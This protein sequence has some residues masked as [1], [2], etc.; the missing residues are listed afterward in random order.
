VL[1]SST[2]TAPTLI[3]AAEGEPVALPGGGSVRVLEQYGSARLE[4]RPSIV[5]KRQRDRSA[6]EFYSMLRV[7]IEGQERWIP[8]HEYVFDGPSYRYEGKFRYEP[9]R[10]ELADGRVVEAIYS[11]ERERLPSRVV[12]DDFHLRAHIGGFTGATPSIR[13]WIS[14]VRFETEDGGWSDPVEI[15]TNNPAQWGDLSFFQA[16]WDPPPSAQ[17]P[18][19]N[20]RS[21]GFA[22]TG[23]GVGNR[24][25]V[26]AMLVSS[27]IS[28]L[29]MLYVFY[30][31]PSIQRARLRRALEASAA[32]QAAAEARDE[33]PQE[34]RETPM[35]VGA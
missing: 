21:G 14:D 16:R 30:V 9:A 31:K 22:F 19:A 32:S 1:L 23:L 20:V 12:L 5:P 26:T 17:G 4:T 18:G 2:G 10:F 33:K 27:S 15:R 24:A 13:D 28:V 6:G 7:A 35:E 25:G 34:S 3:P 29:G 11:R 8:F